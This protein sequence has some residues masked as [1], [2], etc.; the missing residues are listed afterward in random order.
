MAENERRQLISSGSGIANALDRIGDL[1][2]ILPLDD[3]VKITAAAR[4]IRE[5]MAEMETG[6][7]KETPERAMRLCPNC[8]ALVD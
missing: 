8:G 4:W 3:R 2:G 1:K 7:Q 5:A 6:A